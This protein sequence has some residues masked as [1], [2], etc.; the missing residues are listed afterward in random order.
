MFLIV[1]MVRGDLSAFN[2]SMSLPI[3]RQTKTAYLE[4]SFPVGQTGRSADVAENWCLKIS[5]GAFK[6]LG[7]AQSFCL[8]TYGLQILKS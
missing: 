7:A 4:Q 3:I 5:Q 2:P 1:P 8:Y 6:L